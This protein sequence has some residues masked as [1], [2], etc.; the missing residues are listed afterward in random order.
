[1]LSNMSPWVQVVRY[2][3][4]VV[5]CHVQMFETVRRPMRLIPCAG[6]WYRDIEQI[7]E[8]VFVCLDAD[9]T[10][11]NAFSKVGFYGVTGWFRLPYRKAMPIDWQSVCVYIARG[12]RHWRSVGEWGR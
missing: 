2:G 7:I 11:S 8:I 9:I 1:M 4:F 6:R 3:L 12:L 5:R 10:N